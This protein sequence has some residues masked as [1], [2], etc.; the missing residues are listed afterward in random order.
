MKDYK[1]FI[2]YILTPYVDSD[3]NETA[4]RS[5]I[6]LYAIMALVSAVISAMN[7]KHNYMT[8]AYT[9]IALSIG[10]I[11]DSILCAKKKP[12]AAAIICGLQATGIFT[13]YAVVGENTDGCG[14]V[15]CLIAYLMSGK[16]CVFD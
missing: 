2:K 15:Q 12:R 3:G 13:Y 9:T 1:Q 10:F 7:I 6:V 11:L 4:R 5:A 14:N 16:L 8:M